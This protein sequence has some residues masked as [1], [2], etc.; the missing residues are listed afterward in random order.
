M[1]GY[2]LDA[3]VALSWCFQDEASPSHWRLLD[4][5][6]HER[7]RVPPLWYIEVANGLINAERRRRIDHRGI[8]RALELLGNLP[9]M[10][11]DGMPLHAFGSILDLGRSQ[12]LTA[13][14]AAYLELAM[15][16]GVPLAT[17]DGRLCK[18]AEQLG[19]PVL[20]WV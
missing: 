9:I 7:A 15:R 2:V 10:M 3:S 14:D 4:S 1:T 18:A 13:Y 5:L 8:V 17:A 11:D 19:V 16:L 12:A 6:A 20:G